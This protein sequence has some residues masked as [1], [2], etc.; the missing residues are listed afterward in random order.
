MRIIN[1]HTHYNFTHPADLEKKRNEVWD[2]LGYTQVWFSGNDAG[3]AEM[4]QRYPDYVVGFGALKLDPG[5]HWRNPEVDPSRVDGP[6]AVPRYRDA[7]FLGLK[8]MYVQHPFSYPRYMAVYEKAVELDMPIL[9]HTGY[10]KNATQDFYRPDYLI[11]V[12]QAFPECK[13]M[14]AHLGGQYFWEAVWAITH[15]PNVYADLSG[16]TLR[17][18]PAEFFKTLFLR[19]PRNQTFSEPSVGF[20]METNDTGQPDPAAKLVFGSDNPDDTLPFYHNV[21]NVLNAPS[22]LREKVFFGNAESLL[23][24]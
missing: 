19:V 6:D 11:D 24:S 2:Q 15:C 5:P 22:S 8:I 9:F 20:S 23:P 10:T 21:M 13:I 3:I 1:A 12:A 16:G 18:F 17:Y 7:G 14:I 4:I